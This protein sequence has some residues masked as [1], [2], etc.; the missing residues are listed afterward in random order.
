MRP[1]PNHAGAGAVDGSAGLGSEVGGITVNGSVVGFSADQEPRLTLS[2][3]P[4][5]VPPAPN[6]A[7]VITSELNEIYTEVLGRLPDPSGLATYSAALAGGT[8]PAT[9]RQIV[10]GLA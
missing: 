1:F 7:D 9:I 4:V 10:A 3:E 2:A 6:P 8:S 5:P